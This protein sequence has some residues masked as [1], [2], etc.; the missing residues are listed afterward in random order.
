MNFISLKDKDEKRLMHSKNDNNEIIINNKSGKV[1][2]IV[3]NHFFLQ[4]VTIY[5]RETLLF[6]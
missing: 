1:K 5:L 4:S 2:K 6:M 3:F